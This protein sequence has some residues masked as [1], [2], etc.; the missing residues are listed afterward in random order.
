M[1]G[2]SILRSKPIEIFPMLDVEHSRTCAQTMTSQILHLVS[3][4]AVIKIVL[5]EHVDE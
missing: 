2:F 4:P 3:S 5:H 1:A